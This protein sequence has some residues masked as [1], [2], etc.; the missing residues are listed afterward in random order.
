M[1]TNRRIFQFSAGFQ[2]GDAISQE[3]LELK[4]KFNAFGFENHIYSEN[5]N[6]P[7]R[8][9]AI[10]YTKAKIKPDDILIYH[11]S[12]HTEVLPYILKYQNIK[13][14]IYHN[15]TPAH[16]FE[17]YDLKFT[18]LL[19]EGTKDLQIIKETFNHFFAVSN[20]NRQ[21]LLQNQFDQVH[22][23]PLSLNFSKWKANL[24]PLTKA[25]R[26]QFLFVGRIAPNKRQDDLIRFAKL[27]KEKTN[28]PFKF[29]LVGF[30]NPNQQTYL[31]EL[32]F[33][34]K[35][36]ELTEE[37]QI[38]SHVDLSLLSQYYQESH[39]FISMSEHEGFCVPLMEAMQFNLP[40]IAYDAGAVSETLGGSGVLF[41]NKNFLDIVD[42]ILE[43]ESSL[44]KKNLLIKNQLQ[45][46]ETYLKSSSIQKLIEIL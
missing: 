22:L 26:L 38:V 43:L 16:F 34:I 2:L 37:V 8:S 13:I 36:Y 3:M 17:P 18:Y 1:K 15:V 29:K 44:D 4:N 7:D 28:I 9:I 31:D 30:C 19:S 40:V 20:F 23:L 33:M 24:T 11:H 46:I 25:N 27:W 5:I 35:T 42:I 10:K 21:E 39:Y 12:I 6:K 32:E 41:K 45:R 14:L